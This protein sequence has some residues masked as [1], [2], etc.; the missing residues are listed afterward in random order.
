MSVVLYRPSLDARSGAGQLLALQWRGLTAAGVDTELACERGAL[1]FWLR[2]GVR[3]RRRSVAALQR[4]Q[5]QG[6]VIVDHG[7]SLRSAELVFVHNLA[8]AAARH[9]PGSAAAAAQAAQRE[10]DFFGSLQ[11]SAA[12]VANSKLVAAALH[13]QLGIAAERVT[14]LHP[15]FDSRRYSL[16]RAAELRATARR[17]LGVDAA[18]PLVGLVTSGDFA[19]RG[20]NLFLE[21]AARIAAV[22]PDARFLVVGSKRL[23]DAARAHALVRAGVVHYRPKSRRP[24][25]WFAALDLF[26]YPARFEEFGMVVAEAQAMGVPV[27]TSRR[28]GASECLPREY[29]AWVAEE[30]EPAEMAQRA[31]ALLADV[32]LRARLASAAAA[33]VTAFD[34]RS[35]VAG[36]TRLVAAAQNRR[37]K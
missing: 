13:E 23:P 10:R 9:L 15:G 6:T 31:L 26:L 14:V 18:A 37:L 16:Q 20:L 34:E 1:K 19:K 29:A 27:L 25:P 36:T 17:A 33:S 24:E 22:R 11:T 2:T 5:G 21:S 30:P 35:Y 32:G 28:V 3:A 8:T 4:L 12:V 7:L